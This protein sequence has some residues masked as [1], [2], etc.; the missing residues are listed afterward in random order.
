MIR[1]PD[2]NCGESPCKTTC[3]PV[4]IPTKDEKE[5]LDA[6]RRIKDRVREVK[7][8]IEM[9]AGESSRLE[10]ELK[11]LRLEWDHWQKRREETARERMVLLG[12]EDPD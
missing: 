2:K 1:K 4:E 6:L 7:R 11:G 5:A 10:E 8:K 3:G 12:H 9:G